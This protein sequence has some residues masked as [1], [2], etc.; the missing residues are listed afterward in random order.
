MAHWV[1]AL[2]L[3]ARLPVRMASLNFMTDSPS[4]QRIKSRLDALQ[5]SCATFSTACGLPPSV[6]SNLLRG[7]R[8]DGPKEAMLAD[9]SLRLVELGDTVS[10][11]RLPDNPRDLARLMEHVA[12][13]GTSVEKIRLAMIELFGGQS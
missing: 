12:E 6:F 3:C 2:F 11:L 5:I 13:R 4:M 8:N 1:H 10:P 9:M 7:I